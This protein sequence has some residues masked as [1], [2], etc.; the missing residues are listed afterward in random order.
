MGSLVF[1]TGA[2]TATEP[3]TRAASSRNLSFLLFREPLIPPFTSRTAGGT[4]VGSN[5]ATC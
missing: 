3:A 1:F 4:S 5:P 2:G